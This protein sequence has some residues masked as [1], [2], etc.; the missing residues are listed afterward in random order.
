MFNFQGGYNSVVQC[1]TPADVNMNMANDRGL[2]AVMYASQLGRV[3]YLIA[4]IAPGAT[5]DNFDMEGRFMHFDLE[6]TADTWVLW[7]RCRQ[8]GHQLKSALLLMAVPLASL[9]A[10]VYT[11]VLLLFW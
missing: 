5:L 11:C 6:W 9:Q 8:L 7:L 2:T 10:F 4:L 3:E 1:L